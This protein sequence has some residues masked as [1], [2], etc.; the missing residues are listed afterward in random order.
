[1]NTSENRPIGQLDEFTFYIEM[2]LLWSC[3]RCDTDFE[4]AAIA[5]DELGFKGDWAVQSAKLAMNAG[6]YVPAKDA[7]GNTEL[8][9]LCPKCAPPKA[10]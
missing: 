1:M 4:E 9:C 2:L 6:W 8:L 7:D 10:T 3:D 5:A